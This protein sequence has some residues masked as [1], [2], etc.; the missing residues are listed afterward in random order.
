VFFFWTQRRQRWKWFCLLWHVV[1]SISLCDYLSIWHI[2]SSIY[3]CWMKRGVIWQGYSL[4]K[5]CKRRACVNIVFLKHILD[6]KSFAWM[7]ASASTWTRV[8]F[9]CC[10]LCS[11]TMNIT[12]ADVLSGMVDSPVAQ[13][14]FCIV[15]RVSVR[16]SLLPGVWHLDSVCHVRLHA[17]SGTRCSEKQPSNWGTAVFV[18]VTVW[19]FHRYWLRFFK[20]INV[21]N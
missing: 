1:W 2:F 15:D 21:Q 5:T 14:R 6:N 9:C 13:R 11:V 12:L 7:C 17:R 16:G 20:P 4:Y 18:S 3:S 19:W 10:L 8:I